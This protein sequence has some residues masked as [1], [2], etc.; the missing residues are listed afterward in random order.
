MKDL[1]QLLEEGLDAE[2]DPS[3]A[4]MRVEYAYLRQVSIKM[5]RTMRSEDQVLILDLTQEFLANMV[6]AAKD[7]SKQVG[8]VKKNL[9]RQ[10]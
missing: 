2:D 1:S 8:K 3:V 4:S 5:A 7:I 6:R 10:K 9:R